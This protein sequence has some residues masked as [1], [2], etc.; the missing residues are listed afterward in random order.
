MKHSWYSLTELE[1]TLCRILPCPAAQ[2]LT[3]FPVLL[4][5]RGAFQKMFHSGGEADRII[6]GDDLYIGW[7]FEH[8]KLF[9]KRWNVRANDGQSAI[10]RFPEGEAKSFIGRRQNHPAC[11]FVQRIYYR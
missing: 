10:Y 1:A 9:S 5:I 2:A 6:G 8:R 7:P 11:I 3:G 4:G